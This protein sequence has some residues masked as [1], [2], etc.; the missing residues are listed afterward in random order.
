VGLWTFLH[1]PLVPPIN[2]AA[3]RALRDYVI[4]RKLSYCTHSKREMDFFERIFSTVQTCK[5]QRRVAC[6]FITEA[7]QSLVRPMTTSQPRARTHPP[8]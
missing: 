3:E 6:E 8:S 4:K 5:M 2:N 1:N 7:I